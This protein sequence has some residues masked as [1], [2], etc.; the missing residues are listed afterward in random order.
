[1]AFLNWMFP[2]RSPRS[3]LY[4]SRASRLVTSF[5]YA[6]KLAVG[7]AGAAA[8]VDSAAL[9][10]AGGAATDWSFISSLGKTFFQGRDQ[11]GEVA[12]LMHLRR[13]G[14]H[15]FE[16]KGQVGDVVTDFVVTV[17]FLADALQVGGS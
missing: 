5:M 2:A 16:E 15:I 1:M 8:G 17:D 13:E 11:A 3:S 10:G 4:P 7:A 12:V 9:T 14:V 6:S